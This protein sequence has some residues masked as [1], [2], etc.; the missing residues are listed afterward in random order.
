MSWQYPSSIALAE[1]WQT[2]GSVILAGP[3]NSCCAFHVQ[4]TGSPRV[5][6]KITRN[7]KR[8]S[9]LHARHKRIVRQKREGTRGKRVRDRHKNACHPHANSHVPQVW[10]V[11]MSRGLETPLS[12]PPSPQ[13]IPPSRATLLFEFILQPGAQGGT[14][15]ASPASRIQ[16]DAEPHRTQRPNYGHI[17]RKQ[18]KRPFTGCGSYREDLLFFRQEKEK[19]W[20]FAPCLPSRIHGKK[21]RAWSSGS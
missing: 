4:D 1:L 16:L 11:C 19:D 20:H 17:D 9:K 14:H 13:F 15:A 6:S 12:L 21:A 5:Y 10:R 7:G 3:V 2:S 18:D 8:S